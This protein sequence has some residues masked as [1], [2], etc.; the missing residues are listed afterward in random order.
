MLKK[1][2]KLCIIGAG[3]MG[4]KHLSYF[5]KIDGVNV[6]AFSENNI[7]IIGEKE[8]E[9][10][11]KG[12]ENYTDMLKNENPDAVV[13]CTPI[14]THCQIIKDVASYKYG[15]FCEKP[16]CASLQEAQ[17]L[18]KIILKDKIPFLVGYAHLYNG[19]VVKAKSLINSN[20]IGKIKMVIGGFGGL[21]KYKR[22]PWFNKKSIAGGGVILDN[23]SHAIS[24]FRFLAGE[25]IHVSSLSDNPLFTNDEVEY[26]ASVQIKSEKNIIGTFMSSSEIKFFDIS[27]FDIYGEGGTVKIDYRKQHQ[28]SMIKNQDDRWNDIPYNKSD[29]F[30]LQAEHFINILK[31][32]QKSRCNVSD[33]RKI[34][35]IIEKAYINMH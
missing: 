21:S 12:Y 22:P 34:Q 2:M 31:G 3:R 8:K 32:K 5:S 25:G 4:E 11:I 24:V 23:I 15:I 9:F 27:G 20:E 18:E 26:S 30:Q 19:A 33:G 10:G 1:E 17:E 14:K 7:Q 13:I 29:K 6:T 16:L 28:L 35:E